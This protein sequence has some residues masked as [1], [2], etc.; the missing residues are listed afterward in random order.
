MANIAIEKIPVFTN[1]AVMAATTVETILP[2][3]DKAL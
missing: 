2:H 1:G 3:F